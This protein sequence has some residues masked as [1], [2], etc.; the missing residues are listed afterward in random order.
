M[1]D[2]AQINPNERN[3]RE[4]IKVS[5]KD[6]KT[7]TREQRGLII[8]QKYRITKT[9]EGYKVPSQFNAGKYLVKIHSIGEECDCPDYELRKCRCKHI[10]AVLYAINQKVEI[11][12]HGNTIVTQTK[13][14]KITYQQD[15][16]NYNKAQINEQPLFMQLLSD[17]CKNIEQQ[18]YEF[19]RPKIPLA[20]MIFSSTLKV[21]STFSL[22]RFMGFMKTA[23]EKNYLENSCCYST[24]SNYMRNKELTP[25][26]HKLIKISSLPLDSIE[27]K[28]AVDS[29]GFSTCRFARYFSY[30]HG[31]D[32]TYRKWLKAHVITGVKTNI[33]TAVELSEEYENDYTKFKPLV[34]ATAENFKIIEVTGDKAYN[35]RSN[36]KLVESLGGTAYIPF[37]SNTIETPRGSMIWTKMYHL[38]QYN[39]EEFLRHYHLRSNVEST[40]NMIKAKFKDNL[41]SKDKISLQNELLLKILCHNICC[42]IEAMFELNIKPEFNNNINNKEVI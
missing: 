30:K 2:E 14:V 19:G 16:K 35:G 26:L 38:F 23:L 40:F 24:V 41:R 10:Y 8:A 9:N 39:K 3:E 31:K 6:Y 7:L 28:F 25:L 4:N 37:K 20:D 18:K 13:T 21:Y 42:I 17:L 15:W 34:E 36:L 29:S 33:I 1:H 11:D 22:R 32:L 5:E 12:K 27:N